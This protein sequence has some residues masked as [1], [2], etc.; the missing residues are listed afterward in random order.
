MLSLNAMLYWPQCTLSTDICFPKRRNRLN[1]PRG[2]CSSF[3][4]FSQ[5][6]TGCRSTEST[7]LQ[8]SLVLSLPSS[9]RRIRGPIIPTTVA[10]HIEV[11]LRGSTASIFWCSL[12]S[13]TGG[14]TDF[15][16]VFK[17]SLKLYQN[18]TY[19]LDM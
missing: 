6:P 3:P 14:S 15:E 18:K 9:L 1:K 19:I 10:T 12:N 8:K 7:S 17:S 16:I 2:G 4:V 5:Y 11:R 13:L